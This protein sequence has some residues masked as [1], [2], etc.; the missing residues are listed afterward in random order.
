MDVSASASEMDEQWD[1]YLGIPVSRKDTIRPQMD[2]ALIRVRRPRL[3]LEIIEHPGRNA[4]PEDLRSAKILFQS[5]PFKAD[6]KSFFEYHLPTGIPAGHHSLRM[7]LLGNSSL[8]Q[9]FYDMSSR[10]SGAASVGEDQIVG[11]GKVRILPDDYEG[12][13]ITSD[14]DQTFLD[15]NITTKLG[16]LQTLFESPHEKRPFPGMP[17]FYRQLR[18]DPEDPIPLLFLSSSPHFFRRSLQ[19]LFYHH[20]IDYTGISLKPFVSSLDFLIRNY[21][22]KASHAEELLSGRLAKVIE[23][24][25]R[26]RGKSSDI[27]KLSSHIGYKLIILLENR[28]MQPTHAREIIMGDNT[29]SDFFIFTLY[30]LILTGTLPTGRLEEYLSGLSFRGSS[31]PTPGQIHQIIRLADENLRLHG[32]VNPVH[33]A[34]INIA[35]EAPDDNELKKMILA[36]LPSKIDADNILKNLQGCRGAPGFAM[37]AFDAGLI[38]KNQFKKIWE[39]VEGSSTPDG[40]FYDR[41]FLE[42]TLT[43]YPFLEESRR[44][45]LLNL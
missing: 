4:T 45:E 20:G 18:Y 8:S 25:S 42:R 23:T 11:Y 34:W 43:E 9:K 6:N 36:D 10:S 44:S 17:E 35:Y 1:P 13:I 32:K 2:F 21:M 41:T 31:P 29:E 37:A 33:R 38:G 39:A 14:I 12:Y 30:Q 27:K 40:G 5:E 26:I 15:T 7:I 22:R 3:R 28:L 24:F 16:L 19:T